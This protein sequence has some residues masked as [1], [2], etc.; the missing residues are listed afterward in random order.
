MVALGLFVRMAGHCDIS[1]DTNTA[2]LL[3]NLWN[4]A[5]KHSVLDR[6][7]M[8]RNAC[9]CDVIFCFDPIKKV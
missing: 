5:N 9:S 7:L 2:P 3:I 8:V 1:D 6:K 4:L